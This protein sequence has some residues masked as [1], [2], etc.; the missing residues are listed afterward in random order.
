V[1]TESVQT[2]RAAI[3]Q[4]Q[5][6]N[7]DVAG[8]REVFRKTLLSLDHADLVVA[9]E[10]FISG[11]DL[12]MIDRHR[13]ELSERLDGPTAAIA[14]EVAADR[15]LTIVVGII[16]KGPGGELYDTAILVTPDGTV[17]PYRKSHL[18]PTELAHFAQ[19]NEL[20]VVETP[21]GLLGPQICFEHAFPAIST[22]LATAGA[23]II[24]I[25]SAVGDGYDHLLTLRSRARA[26]DN[27]VFVVAAN[28]NGNG[29]CGHSL[30]ADP[31]GNVLASAGPEDAILYADLDLGLIAAERVQ[32]AS[33]S[34]ARP[35]LYQLAASTS[36]RTVH[37]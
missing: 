6:P 20:F 26:Q 15:N 17:T 3:I 10:L 5:L 36:S 27:Q 21:A 13:D 33:L 34:M 29:F 12:E 30:I 23:Q 19:G 4:L 24:V 37:E 22:T 25:P 16:E 31:S 1:T 11:Y 2:V 14:R 18:F 7:G 32:E 28:L 9:P 35:E 8:N